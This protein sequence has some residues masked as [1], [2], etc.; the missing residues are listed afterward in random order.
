MAF[1]PGGDEVDVA[2]Y[3]KSVQRSAFRRVPQKDHTIADIE[4]YRQDNSLVRRISDPA[5]DRS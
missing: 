4:S 3:N 1:S 2:S 5:R